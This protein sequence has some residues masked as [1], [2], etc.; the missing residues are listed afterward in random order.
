MILYSRPSP[1]V[2]PNRPRPLILGPFPPPW[3]GLDQTHSEEK[4]K[5][6]LAQD[7]GWRQALSHGLTGCIPVMAD[8]MTAAGLGGAL[9]G[10]MG[11]RG[12]VLT[13]HEG[14]QTTYTAE[15]GQWKGVSRA[16][17]GRKAA[18]DPWH[19][20]SNRNWGDC[21]HLPCVCSEPP[22][23][24]SCRPGS[25]GISKEATD[26]DFEGAVLHFQFNLL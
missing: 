3:E 8:T 17:Q 13:P 14:P 1:P 5:F 22:P 9:W 25:S 20:G 18:T 21:Q 19:L 26:L 7:T 15:K 4:V 11:V 10:V 12:S 2:L 24:R 16:T 6:P 23:C